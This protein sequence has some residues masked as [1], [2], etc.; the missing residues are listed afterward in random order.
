MH[1]VLR[2]SDGVGWFDRQYAAPPESIHDVGLHCGP[3]IAL[4]VGQVGVRG[5]GSMLVRE[6][7]CMVV[8]VYHGSVCVCVYVCLCVCVCVCVRV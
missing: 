3:S 1:S 4:E 5:S 6:E 7:M 2:E 8:C